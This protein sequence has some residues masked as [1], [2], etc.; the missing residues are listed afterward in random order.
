MS[1]SQLDTKPF[2]LRDKDET[3][4]VH[5]MLKFI[6]LV[7]IYEDDMYVAFPSRTTFIFFGSPTNRPP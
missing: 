3:P 4:E 5:Q 7:T 2:L 6:P 1:S